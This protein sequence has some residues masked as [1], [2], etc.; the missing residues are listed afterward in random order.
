M[1]RCCARTLPLLFLEK[2]VV[3]DCALRAPGAF[4]ALVVSSRWATLAVTD[5]G[6]SQQ[7]VAAWQ[8]NAVPWSRLDLVPPAAL[9]HPRVSADHRDESMQ[10][11]WQDLADLLRRLQSTDFYRRDPGMVEFCVRFCQS[12][13]DELDVET[14][15]QNVLKPGKP[16]F[17]QA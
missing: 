2:S 1:T 16:F 12:M 11:T 5:V 3:F 13:S 14:A 8:T 17:A 6:S 4:I 9:D 7:G 15:T 10:A